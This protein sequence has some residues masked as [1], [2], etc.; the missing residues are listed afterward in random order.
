MDGLSLEIDPQEVLRLQGYRRPSD[1]PTPEVLA[2]LQDAMAEAQQVFQPRWVYRE[3][4]TESVDLERCRLQGGRELLIREIPKRWGPITTLGLAVCTIGEA[5][6]Q[7]I[8]FLFAEREFPVAYMLDS[9]G[10]VAAEALA[11]GV[12]RQLCAERLAL[13]FKVTPRESPGYLGWPIEEQRTVFALL[14]T[15][16]IGVGLNPYCIMI[17][18]KSISFAVGIGP[19]AKMGST[20]SP[21]QSCDMRNCAYRRAPRG[22]TPVPAWTFSVSPLVLDFSQNS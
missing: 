16:T 10:S 13:G 6:E 17:P 3:F 12:L 2:I 20:F 11:E 7:R 14:P 22:Q 8:E 9:L 15:A 5:I 1:V 19:E 4:G 21:C 18:R